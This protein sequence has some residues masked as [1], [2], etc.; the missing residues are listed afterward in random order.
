MRRKAEKPTIQGEDT[1]S[2][3]HILMA[4]LIGT[5]FLV[6]GALL[7]NKWVMLIA[8]IPLLIALAQVGLLVAMAL[9]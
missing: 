1:M 6:V 7:K 8:A 4:F 9:H 2:I 5:A 3:L